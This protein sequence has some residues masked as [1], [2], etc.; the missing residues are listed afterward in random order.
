MGCFM[1]EGVEKLGFGTGAREVGDK[2]MSPAK[3][4]PHKETYNFFPEIVSHSMTK[5]SS[6]S[7]I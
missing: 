2:L 7:R 6:T 4:V 5:P 3:F 1:S